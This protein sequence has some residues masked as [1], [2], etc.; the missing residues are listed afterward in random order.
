MR[1]T[2]RAGQIEVGHSRAALSHRVA[3]VD[4]RVIIEVVGG[5]AAVHVTVLTDDGAQ[6]RAL[7]QRLR[8]WLAQLRIEADLQVLHS[9]LAD[10]L[11]P[12]VLRGVPAATIVEFSPNLAALR[13]PQR[14]ARHRPL[15]ARPID[16]TACRFR[17]CFDLDLLP[18][19]LSEALLDE[20]IAAHPR[21]TL[22]LRALR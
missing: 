5:D 22:T 20:R 12:Q 1:P 11:L 19:E 2:Q 16:G 14:I 8:V 10:M 18:L 21:I 9:P 15:L 17:T 3:Q 13:A 7:E 6:L 4:A